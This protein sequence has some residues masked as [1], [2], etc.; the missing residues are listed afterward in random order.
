MKPGKG[1]CPDDWPASGAGGCGCGD[2]VSRGAKHGRR[3]AAV[4]KVLFVML[5]LAALG[6]AGLFL[7]MGNPDSVCTDGWR[8]KNGTVTY[9]SGGAFSEGGECSIVAEAGGTK[10]SIGESAL[11]VETPFSAPIR[12][13]VSISVPVAAQLDR[14]SAPPG[15]TVES[16]VT[17]AI[18]RLCRMF[19]EKEPGE[20]TPSMIVIRQEAEAWLAEEQL[21]FVESELVMRGLAE[22]VIFEAEAAYL[23][24][25]RYEIKLERNG[26]PERGVVDARCWGYFPKDKLRIID[27]GDIR[28]GSPESSSFL[29]PTARHIIR[30]ASG[31][32]F[33]VVFIA[34]A[35]L[36]VDAGTHGRYTWPL[37]ITAVAGFGGVCLF[38]WYHGLPLSS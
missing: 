24:D 35:Y 16:A 22:Q 15:D 26:T 5:F 2:S 1:C 36:F 6:V 38:L 27:T 7:L 8:T 34:L 18:A 12:I 9:S 20:I 23:P 21:R 17:E 19:Q 25:T 30:Q 28:Y 10:V 11:Q 13:P 31:A 4:V 37:R 14:G 33:L 32:G 3:A 29:D